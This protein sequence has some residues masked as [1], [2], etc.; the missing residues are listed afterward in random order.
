MLKTAPVGLQEGAGGPSFTMVCFPKDMHGHPRV[1]D[2]Y[3][4]AV[5]RWVDD[6]SDENLLLW[7]L[8][9]LK[10]KVHQSRLKANLEAWILSAFK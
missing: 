2:N 4:A 7:V 5:T 8:N 3:M 10:L 9:E 1:R 6:C